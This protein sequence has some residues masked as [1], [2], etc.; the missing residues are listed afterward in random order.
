M[1]WVALFLVPLLFTM[2]ALA[3]EEEEEKAGFATPTPSPT[4]EALTPTVSQP[5]PTPEST[6]TPA[7]S[8]ITYVGTDL[9]VWIMNADGSGLEKLFDINADPG[10]DT[11][12]DLEWSPDGTRLAITKLPEDRYAPEGVLFIIGAAGE[13]LVEMP[14][15]EFLTWSPRADMFAVRRPT[16][17]EGNS[18]IVILDLEGNAVVEPLSGVGLAWSADQ[19]RVTFFE[20]AG[21]VG[22]CGKLRGLLA[23]LQTGDVRPI[24]PDE[25]PI[26]C[27]HPAIFSPINPSLLA[28]GDRLIDVDTGEA[29]PLPGQAVHWSKDGQLLE[30]CDGGHVVV[31]DVDRAASVLEFDTTSAPEGPCWTALRSWTGWSPDSRLLGVLELNW[32]DPDAPDDVIHI[33]DVATGEDKTVSVSTAGARS[34]QFSPDGSYLLLES[35]PAIWLVDSEGKSLTQIEGSAATWL[36]LP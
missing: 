1:K 2:L 25:E 7:A 23:S 10:T 36:P 35:S 27:G 26:D 3:C 21:G 15:V 9:D 22:L 11:I 8:R 16:T 18:A 34:L 29:R 19:Q 14:G 20:P 28:Y 32:K 13:T 30:T 6:T 33:R 12:D 5:S 17:A 31:Y 4:G 24:D